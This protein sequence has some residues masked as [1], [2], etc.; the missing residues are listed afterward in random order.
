MFQQFKSIFPNASL[1]IR[2][3][4]ES[5]G[6]NDTEWNR[7]VERL[8]ALR[9]EFQNLNS[10]FL[11]RQNPSDTLSN[12]SPASETEPSI[13]VK[14]LKATGQM[15]HA[16]QE[17][18]DSIHLGN[19]SNFEKARVVDVKLR[20]LQ[21]AGDLHYK[22]CE[23]ME[24]ADNEIREIHSNL[25][26]IQSSAVSLMSIL[27]KIEEKIDQVSI[28]YEKNQFEWW[29][30]EQEKELMDEIANRRQLLR[31][32]D[33]KLKQQ[34]EE[35]DSIQQRKRVE[36]Y[37]ANFNAELEDYRRRRE[38]EVSSLYSYQSNTDRITTS[39]DQVK[40]QDTRED[41]DQFLGNTTSPALLDKTTKRNKIRDRSNPKSKPKPEPVFSSEDDD[42]NGGK[43]EILA[44]EDYED[45]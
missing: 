28:Y 16:L 20:Q 1:N 38:T 6:I 13:S 35:H 42:D 5:V 10:I 24:N 29:K 2:S 37:E 32:K 22:A 8:G 26:A 23:A 9:N 34:Y 15:I 25:S 44:D 27:E 43:I 18:W 36:L 4:S 17:G 21:E 3:I 7:G 41:L 45:L 33:T 31:E 19:Q 12:H 14:E 11:N 40:L 30:Q 39:L